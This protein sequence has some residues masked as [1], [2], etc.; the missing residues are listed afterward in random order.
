M[1]DIGESATS[2]E[3]GGEASGRTAVVYLRVSSVGQIN[4]G[5]DPEGYSIPGQREACQLHAER[6]GASVIREYVEP[7]KSGTSTNR[8]ALQ[9]MLSDLSELEIDYV[10]VYDQIDDDLVIVQEV[11]KLDLILLLSIF[12]NKSKFY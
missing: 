7:G 8:P 9:K 10:I 4:K 12:L 5:T 11:V 2:P 3:P 1:L 6:L